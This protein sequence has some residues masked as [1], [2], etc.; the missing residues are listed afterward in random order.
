[1]AEYMEYTVEKVN[2]IDDDIKAGYEQS[3]T[4]DID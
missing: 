1:M 2:S 4:N 3:W